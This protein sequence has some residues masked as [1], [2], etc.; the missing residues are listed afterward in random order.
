[1]DFSKGLENDNLYFCAVGDNNNSV[2]CAV[3]AA[4]NGG[5]IGTARR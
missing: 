5:Y 4:A 2:N 1:M 3:D